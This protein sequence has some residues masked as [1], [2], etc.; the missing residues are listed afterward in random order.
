MKLRNFLAR[1]KSFFVLPIA[2][3]A[4]DRKLHIQGTLHSNDP[5]AADVEVFD[6]QTGRKVS[7]MLAVNVEEGW[8]ERYKTDRN[9]S[10]KFRSSGKIVRWEQKDGKRI[11]VYEEGWDVPVLER[12]HGIFEVRRKLHV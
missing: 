11:P 2:S 10:I 6:A 7:R 1:L 12:R 8:L 5:R 3:P 4:T 9:G